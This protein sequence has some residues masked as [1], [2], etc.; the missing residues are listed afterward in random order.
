MVNINSTLSL[1]SSLEQSAKKDRESNVN[2]D[3]YIRKRTY[4]L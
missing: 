1:S 4:I 2:W 3:M